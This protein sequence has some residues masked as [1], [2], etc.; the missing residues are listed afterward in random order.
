MM[1]T[2]IAL[3]VLLT[4]F[5][6]APAHARTKHHGAAK[7]A[8]PAK[9]KHANSTRAGKH[10]KAARVVDDDDDDDKPAPKSAPKAVPKPA[11]A[12]VP[13]ASAQNRNDR[14]MDS[15]SM[16]YLTALWRQ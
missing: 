1:K 5:A 12:L 4:S 10:G 3:A 6:L 8:A 16:Q 2:R 15:L 11:P 13:A 7:A 9:G 14:Y